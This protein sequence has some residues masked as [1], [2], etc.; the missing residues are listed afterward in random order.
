MAHG[1]AAND[2]PAVMIAL[3]AEVEIICSARHL[4]LFSIDEFFYGFYMTAVQHGEILTEIRIP[5]A[6][7]VNHGSAYH[8]AET[9]G[10]RLCHCRCGS[11]TFRLDDS[12][13]CY[14]SWNRIDK[15]QCHSHESIHGPRKY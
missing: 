4:E 2:H 11:C 7:M 15:C 14:E 12:G 3:G 6:C 8:K 9:E 5:G 10:W 13:V 1:D